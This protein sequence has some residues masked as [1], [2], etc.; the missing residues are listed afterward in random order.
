MLT[1]G[2]HGRSRAARSAVAP[3]DVYVTVAFA[4]MICV[5]SRSAAQIASWRVESGASC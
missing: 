4:P 5:T 2:A 1:I 3:D